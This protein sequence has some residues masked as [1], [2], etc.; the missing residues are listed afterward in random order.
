LPSLAGWIG[1]WMRR[2]PVGHNARSVENSRIVNPG[3]GFPSLSISFPE[4]SPI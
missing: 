1:C 3:A 4:S 2:D